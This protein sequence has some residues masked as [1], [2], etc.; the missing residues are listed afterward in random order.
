M[1]TS[2][3]ARPS[4]KRMETQNFHKIS[5]EVSLIVIP[6]IRFWEH[7]PKIK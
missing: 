1:L 5:I 6:K 2:L 4:T 3:F 7:L